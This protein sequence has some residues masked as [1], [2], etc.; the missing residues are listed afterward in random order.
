MFTEMEVVVSQQRTYSRQIPA[1]AKASK[2]LTANDNYGDRFQDS[3]FFLLMMLPG[4]QV[5]LLPSCPTMQF[6]HTVYTLSMH[7]SSIN[8]KT[9][10]FFYFLSLNW[11]HDL[12][13]YLHVQSY[14]WWRHP[15]ID[16]LRYTHRRMPV[17]TLLYLE[18]PKKVNFFLLQTDQGYR[19]SFCWG[20]SLQRNRISTKVYTEILEVPDSAQGR[21]VHKQGMEKGSY[22]RVYDCK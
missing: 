7:K 18:R 22:I 15:W 3:Q 21:K 17:Q 8:P 16:C 11:H 1:Q 14:K 6:S 10:F 12:T 2:V 5:M 9:I 4:D 13:A 19:F 20:E